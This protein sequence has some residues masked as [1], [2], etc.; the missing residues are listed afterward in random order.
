MVTDIDKYIGKLK[1][2]YTYVTEDEIRMILKH[3]FETLYSLNRYGSDVEVGDW[4]TKAYFGYRF[5]NDQYRA[6]YNYGKLRFKLRSIYKYSNE[7]FNGIYYFALDDDEF[8]EYK[9]QKTKTKKF[10]NVKLYKIKE[11]AFITN[12]KHFFAVFYPFDAGWTIKKDLLSTRS[13]KYFAYRDAQNNII[14]I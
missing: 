6:E 9:A 10:K 7:D 11:E 2:R 4:R 14:N 1:E 3:G 12:K 13:C 8:K 5:N